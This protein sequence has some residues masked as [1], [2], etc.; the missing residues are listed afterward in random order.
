MKPGGRFSPPLGA[1]GRGGGETGVYEVAVFV[2]K[3]HRHSSQNGAIASRGVR[4]CG[5]S[6]ACAVAFG[7]PPIE[8]G[9]GGGTGPPGPG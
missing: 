8:A 3:F 5:H 2:R 1:D 9:G 4:H 6:S 7:S